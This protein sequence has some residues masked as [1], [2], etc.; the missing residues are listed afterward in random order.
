MFGRFLERPDLIK[1]ITNAIA[2]RLKYAR[3]TISKEV[4]RSK[5]TAGLLKIFKVRDCYSCPICA[6]YG[7]FKRYPAL[8]GRENAE[9]PICGSL[10]RHRL[11]YLVFQRV[12]QGVDITKLRMLHFA[13][14]SCIRNFFKDIFVEYI[15]ADLRR[16]DVDRRE[17]IT[18][19]SF[20]DD[21][22]DFLFASHVL[23]HIKDDR[24]ALSEIRRVLRPDGIAIIPVPIIGEKTVEYEEP[25]PND[26][27][28]I[29]C[30]GMDYYDKYKDYFSKIR[31]FKSYDFDEAYQLYRYDNIL[32]K[33]EATSL[34]APGLK[35][36]YVDIVPVCYK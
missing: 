13:P 6:Y 11:Q 21:Y 2:F 26:S 33:P 25:D 5:I 17:D 4:S 9:C 22:L 19:L 8:E 35:R 10:E 20:P 16:G 14:E 18:K 32:K 31:F 15:T 1:K 28:H 27:F 7:R 23:E 36:R 24:A 34:R 12:A 30:P 3:G 29:R